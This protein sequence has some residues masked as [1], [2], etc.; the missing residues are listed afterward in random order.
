MNCILLD[1]SAFVFESACFK[2]CLGFY[3]IF[4]FEYP[5]NNMNNDVQ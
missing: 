2:K 3:L 5:E 4:L 1:V